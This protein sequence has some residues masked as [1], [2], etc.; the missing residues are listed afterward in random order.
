[1]VDKSMSKPPAFLEKTRE[2]ELIVTGRNSGKLLPRPV[3]FS[4][5]GSEL[6]LIPVYGTKT[7]WYKNILR[8]PQVKI[9]ASGQ[10]LHGNV[11]TITSSKE[12]GE[13]IK[14]FEQKYG[15]SDFKKYYPN[16]NVAASL[17]V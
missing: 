10:T 5:R 11:R 14:L 16:P 1:M 7:Q 17:Q 6:L 15:V 12:V 9:K 13:V 8:N 3:W 2:I 4:M